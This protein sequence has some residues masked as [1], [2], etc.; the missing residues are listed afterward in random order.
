MSWLMNP[1]NNV[2][3]NMKY[4]YVGLFPF[5]FYQKLL[6]FLDALFSI[7]FVIR[8]QFLML[9]DKILFQSS[10]KI[11]FFICVCF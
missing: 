1:A 5:R 6:R 10:L 11:T 7:Y 9:A 2:I 3:K 4:K 8:K